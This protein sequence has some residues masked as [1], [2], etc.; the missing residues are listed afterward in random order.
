MTRRTS[1][2]TKNQLIEEFNAVVADTEQLLKSGAQAG[3]EKADALRAGVERNLA[4][5]KERLREFQHAA[6]EKTRATAQA[7]D[8]YV[9]EHPWQGIGIASGVT[10]VLGVVVGLLLNRR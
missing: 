9:H 2:V 7:A 3:G 6:I 8:E 5:A 1:E 10:A 4:S